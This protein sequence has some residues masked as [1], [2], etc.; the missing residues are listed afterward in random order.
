MKRI[1]KPRPKK[2]KVIGIYSI[3]CKT[4]AHVYIGSSTFIEK[5]WTQHKNELNKSKH[6]NTHLQNAWTKYGSGDFA[7]EIVEV[8]TSDKL[9]EREQYHY[10]Q[11]KIK[12]IPLFNI[13]D[14]I[15]AGPNGTRAIQATKEQRVAQICILLQKGKYRRE[16]LEE[17]KD[18][19]LSPRA[20]DGYIAE[21]NEIVSKDIKQEAKDQMNLVS[22]MMWQIYDEA[23][24]A[25]NLKLC[26]ETLMDI[27]KFKGLLG[28][29]KPSQNVTIINNQERLNAMSVEDLESMLDESDKPSRNN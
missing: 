17:T 3:T 8:T 27:A 13:V 11:L 21:A 4:N 25:G 26:R 9:I 5:R 18:W 20:V 1:R 10:D 6:A 7:F 29:Q 2:A 28:D 16:I 24:A 14:N 12:Q 23:Y 15:Q 22:T 19:G